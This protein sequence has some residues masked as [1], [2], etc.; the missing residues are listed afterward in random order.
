MDVFEF[1]KVINEKLA[2]YESRGYKVVAEA[3]K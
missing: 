3:L 2:V 1:E